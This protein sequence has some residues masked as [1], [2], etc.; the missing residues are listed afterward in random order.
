VAAKVAVDTQ[1]IRE[2]NSAAILQRL[3]AAGSASVTELAKATGLSRQAVTR[4]LTALNQVGLVELLAPDRSAPRSG[5]PAQLVRFRAEAGY[6]VGASIS[7]QGVRVALADLAGN[8]VAAADRHLSPDASAGDAM[9]A[10][11][12]LIDHVLV[13]AG[14]ALPDV[15]AASAGA[16]G[17][18]DPTARVIKLIPSMPG[19]SGDVLVRSLEAQLPCPVYLDNDIKLATQGER[20]H[21]ERRDDRS[22]VLVHWGERVGAGIVLNGELYRGATNDAGDLG[23]LDLLVGSSPGEAARAPH[24]PHGLGRFEAWVGAD[25]IVRLALVACR[26]GGDSATAERIA[27][28][29]DAALQVVI[30]AALEDVPACVEAVTEAASRF[31]MGIA[32]IRAILDP[33]LV[34]IGGPVA[35]AGDLILDAV[36]RQLTD[37]PLDPPRLEISALGEDAVVHGALRRA[38]DDLEAARLQRTQQPVPPSQ[39]E[40]HAL[41]RDRSEHRPP[42]SPP[43]HQPSSPEGARQ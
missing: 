43:A 21:G 7:P 10:L 22:L 37:Q 17:I 33:K 18:V 35:R 42:E 28:A 15:W 34:V 26:A 16:P 24:D 38:L 9:E 5:R 40:A 25:E 13:S 27:A 11:G 2:I 41:T 20:W 12:T 8:I 39:R 36:H 31:A 6:V 1:F 14:V 30:D 3:R 23:F 32:A 29:G 19:L 4:S